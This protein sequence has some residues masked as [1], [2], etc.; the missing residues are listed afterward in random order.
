MRHFIISYKKRPLGESGE[1]CKSNYDLSNACVDCGTGA[2]LIGNLRVKGFSN[3]NKD[4]F[5]TLDGDYIISTRLYNLIKESSNDLN[6]LKVIDSKNNLLDFY[7]FANSVTLPRFKKDSTGFLIDRQ[8]QTCKRNGYF[9]HAEIGDLEKNIPTM[10]HPY[11]FKY[12]KNN[13]GKYKNE[14]ILNTWESFG[15]SNK[16]ATGKYV[17]RYARPLIIVSEK[18]KDIFDRE[19]LNE[20]KYEQI[21]IE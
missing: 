5:E 8:C 17:I 10:I 18:I 6:L 13:L 1:S 15:L 7:H 21:I 12:D 2:K 4:F 20:I 14:L 19:K 11:I 3:L 16:I 9:T